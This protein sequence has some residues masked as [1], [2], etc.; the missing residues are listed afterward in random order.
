LAKQP[1]P[2]ERGQE[3][4]TDAD[5]TAPMD[6]DDDQEGSKEAKE[7]EREEEEEGKEQE[8]EEEGDGGEGEEEE[9]EEEAAGQKGKKGKKQ[10]R[11]GKK[12]KKGGEKPSNIHMM[13]LAVIQHMCS[14]APDRADVRGRL[15]ESVLTLVKALFITN[16]AIAPRFVL[17]L[18]KLIRSAKVNDR[19]TSIILYSLRGI[20]HFS[21]YLVCLQVSHR[22]FGVEVASNFLLAPW[23]WT[24]SDDKSLVAMVESFT[25]RILDKA[26]TVRVR[27]MVCLSDML[28]CLQDPDTPKGMGREHVH[29]QG[30]STD[31]MAVRCCLSLFSFEGGAGAVGLSS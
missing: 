22:S 12:A 31:F 23:A 5:G 20:R 4:E 28:N 13:V 10:K 26:P 2:A 25:S 15:A 9:E 19:R 1:L 11:K 6:V 14:E 18:A 7:G 30:K 21:S 17:F 3:E 24:S 16:P 8:D 29:G 27:A